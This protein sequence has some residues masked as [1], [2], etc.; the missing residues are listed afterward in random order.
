M[1]DLD[2]R[3]AACCALLEVRGLV[4]GRASPAPTRIMIPCTRFDMTRH[5][6]SHADVSRVEETPGSHPEAGR[7]KKIEGGS[8][9]IPD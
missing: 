6:S 3:G 5:A 4:L 8:L 7:A 9:S 1:W 2:R